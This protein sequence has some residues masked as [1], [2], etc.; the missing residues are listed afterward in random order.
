MPLKR[1]IK[2][3]EK[4]KEEET[5]EYYY[6]WWLVRVPLYTEK[7]YE[8]FEEFYDKA[9]PKK[10]KYDARDKEEIMKEI[11]QIEKTFEERR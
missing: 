2:L 3:I 6:R 10:I 1:A 4:A 5:K 9:K 8:T 7:T 11:K